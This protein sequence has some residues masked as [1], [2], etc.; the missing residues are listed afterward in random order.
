MNASGACSACNRSLVSDLR[1]TCCAARRCVTSVSS[2][3]L[4]W[5]KRALVDDRSSSRPR[6]RNRSLSDCSMLAPTRPATTIIIEMN[7]SAIA[8]MAN[9]IHSPLSSIEIAKG[10]TA[11]R[12]NAV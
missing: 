5:L 11:G 10:S 2:A 9:G 8:P 6:L 12:M 3:S 7:N 4:T 1:S